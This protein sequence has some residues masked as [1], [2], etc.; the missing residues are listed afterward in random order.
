MMPPAVAIRTY[1]EHQRFYNK[2]QHDVAKAA[3]KA[4]AVDPDSVLAQ[5]AVSPRLTAIA[6]DFNA[7]VILISGCQDNQ[8]SMDGDHNGAFTEQVL[9]VWN[10]AA[11]RGNYA[12]F[13]RPSQ[14]DCLPAKRPISLRSGRS[15]SSCDSNH[16]ASDAGDE[17]PRPLLVQE[18]GPMTGK[19]WL[20]LATTLP[21]VMAV[22]AMLYA[23]DMSG[24]WKGRLA[25]AD[26]SQA[27]VQI[28]FSAKGFPLYSYTNNQGL[29]RQLELSQ[30]GQHIEYVPPGGGATDDGE[31]FRTR[32]RPIVGRYRR[33]VRTR[34]AGVYGP[35]SEA[36]PWNT[37]SC[38]K[39]RRW[40]HHAHGQPFPETRIRSAAIRIPSWPRAS[41]NDCAES[42]VPD[43]D[44]N[45]ASITRVKLPSAPLQKF[46]FAIPFHRPVPTMPSGEG[47][48]RQEVP[49]MFRPARLFSSKTAARRCSSPPFDQPVRRRPDPRLHGAWGDALSLP[50][51]LAL[52]AQ[53]E[54][55]RW[56]FSMAPESPAVH[57]YRGRGHSRHLASPETL[58]IGVAATSA[59]RILRNRPQAKSW[60]CCRARVFACCRN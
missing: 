4:A 32:A 49:G 39:D 53:Y 15:Q 28:D 6:K 3:G 7:S 42:T 43:I 46:V 30:V 31:E 48:S 14:L 56:L 57:L 16:S 44:E 55:W 11:Y 27:D 54:W 8:T 52:L 47:C 12:N 58:P 29:T 20:T 59:S 33:V 38:P 35:T 45:F 36:A 13:M 50:L 37:R 51:C 2:L 17:G 21:C 41:Y 26:G 22:S 60:P 5:L 40:D 10:H 23:A 1:R 24:A 9:K 19:H 34:E 18:L 25:S